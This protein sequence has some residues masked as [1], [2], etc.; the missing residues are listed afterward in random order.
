[1]GQCI[2]RMRR[3]VNDLTTFPNLKGI[4]LVGYDD[5]NDFFDII[6]RWESKSFVELW[7]HRFAYL[8]KW[9]GKNEIKS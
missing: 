2:D 1:M 8:K 5:E 6:T 9:I 7:T 4:Y 3:H